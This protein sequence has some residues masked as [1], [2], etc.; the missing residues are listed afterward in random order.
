MPGPAVYGGRALAG[1]LR[2]G[3]ARPLP[4]GSKVNASLPGKPHGRVKTLPYE[5]TGTY[6]LWG[7]VDQPITPHVG[8][9]HARPGGAR[10]TGACGKPAG[11]ACPA[12]TAR[13]QGECEPARKV[14]REGQDPPLRTDRNV[15]P[16][17]KSTSTHHPARRGRACPA[18]RCT[19]DGCLREACG[20]GVPG[21]YR[22]P[23]TKTSRP[24][25]RGG[26]FL[27]EKITYSSCWRPSCAGR[28]P[29]CACGCAGSRG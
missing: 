27:C 18:R 14:P 21:P 5:P 13:R 17:G 6:A 11:R 28:G 12:P 16:R 10:R 22:E 26:S 8:A 9:G 23:K 3:H 15:C 1:N 19:A 2:A 25:R 7:K 29:G 20:P 24:N 4:R